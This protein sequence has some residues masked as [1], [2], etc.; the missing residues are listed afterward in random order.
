LELLAR[1]MN[2]KPVFIEDHVVQAAA[3]RMQAS[4]DSDA[5]GWMEWQALVRTVEKQGADFRR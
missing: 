5:Y 2:A 1:Q 4:R 3:E